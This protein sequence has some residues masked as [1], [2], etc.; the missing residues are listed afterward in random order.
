MKLAAC[1]LS[2]AYNFEVAAWFGGN[3]CTPAFLLNFRSFW[4]F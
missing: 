2:G 4:L 1:H 3:L